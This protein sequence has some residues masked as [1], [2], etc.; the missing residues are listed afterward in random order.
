MAFPVRPIA[1]SL[2][3]G[4]SFVNLSYQTELHINAWDNCV[5]LKRNHNLYLIFFYQHSPG[6]G[7]VG[8]GFAG[9]LI[10]RKMKLSSGRRHDVEWFPSSQRSDNCWLSLIEMLYSKWMGEWWRLVLPLTLLVAA[11][12]SGSFHYF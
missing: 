9:N 1:R 2:P 8:L 7:G 6:I 11:F 5:L 10:R 12:S 3:V 4:C